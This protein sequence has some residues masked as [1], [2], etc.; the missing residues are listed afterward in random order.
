MSATEV[1]LKGRLIVSPS[2][3]KSDI[4][5]LMDNSKQIALIV[6]RNIYNVIAIKSICF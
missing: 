1:I 4:D 6:L 5:L 2:V 3:T